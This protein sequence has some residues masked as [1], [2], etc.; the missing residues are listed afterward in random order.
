MS[1]KILVS[2][3]NLSVYI[4]F[5]IVGSLLVSLLP[6]YVNPPT[7]EES[8]VKPLNELIV[9]SN[10]ASPLLTRHKRGITEREAKLQAKL[11]RAS[12]EHMS[13][14]HPEMSLKKENLS[15]CP[16]L[17]NPQ[18]VK[19][20]WNEKRLPKSIVPINY[21]LFLFLPLWGEGSVY[22]GE[23]TITVDVKESTNLILMHTSENEMLSLLNVTDKN[24]NRVEMDCMGVY[25]ENDYLILRAKN[26]F[27]SQMGPYKVSISFTALLD[28][29]ESG[30]FEFKFSPSADAS[31]RNE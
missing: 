15:S 23:V 9:N 14:Y 12:P 22:S 2:Y 5:V 19:Y 20:P 4:L 26:N 31:Y 1:D 11:L 13:K 28:K 18:P 21:D 8:S 30:L 10:Q 25:L 17:D 16:E 29:F 6:I 7:C 24:G 27:T 3:V